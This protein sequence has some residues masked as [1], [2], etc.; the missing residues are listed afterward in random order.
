MASCEQ[1]CH[2]DPR[3]TEKHY[4]H[5]APSYVADTIRLHFPVLGIAGETNI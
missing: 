3:M 4:V 2:A 1:V 5:L